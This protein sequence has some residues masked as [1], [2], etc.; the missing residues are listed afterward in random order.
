MAKRSMWHSSAGR[1]LTELLY[2]ADS[3][4]FLKTGDGYVYI[5]ISKLAQRLQM[6]AQA[7]LDNLEWLE[8]QSLLEAVTIGRTSV[9][10]EFTPS[11]APQKEL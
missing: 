2:G 8:S 1:I 11:R 7:L 9:Y 6:R 5:K 3:E 4:I 10:I